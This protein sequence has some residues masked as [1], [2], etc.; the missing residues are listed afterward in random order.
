MA[1]GYASDAFAQIGIDGVGLHGAIGFTA[2]YDARRA[3]SSRAQRK[4]CWGAADSPEYA[5][6]RSCVPVYASGRGKEILRIHDC[7][8]Y[9]LVMNNTMGNPNYEKDYD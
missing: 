9:F 1:K 5:D 6:P 2:A 3:G 7:F 4:L 8:K